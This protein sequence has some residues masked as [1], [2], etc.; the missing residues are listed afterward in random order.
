MITYDVLRPGSTSGDGDGGPRFG[1]YFDMDPEIGY[2][3]ILSASASIQVAQEQL[4]GVTDANVAKETRPKNLRI[5]WITKESSLVPDEFP[6]GTILPVLDQKT[7]I[8]PAGWV[9]CD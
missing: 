2:A 9:T 4:A 6:V 7:G 1:S 5:V 8:L 3:D